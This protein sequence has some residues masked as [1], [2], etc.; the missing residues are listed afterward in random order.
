MEVAPFFVYFHHFLSIFTIFCRFSPFLSIYMIYALLSRFTFCQKIWPKKAFTATSHVFACMG[1]TW[2]ILMSI[3]I[4]ICMAKGGRGCLRPCYGRSKLTLVSKKE[5]PKLRCRKS[6]TLRQF[7][8]DHL[9]T[10]RTWTP[11]WWVHVLF[12]SKRWDENWRT[13]FDL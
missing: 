8:S 3:G 1:G 12:V 6:K 10:N 4:R 9:E 7:L 5:K 11:I 2:W 13:V